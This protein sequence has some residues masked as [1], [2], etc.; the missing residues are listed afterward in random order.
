[1]Q[2][3]GLRF[4]TGKQKAK[5]KLLSNKTFVFTGELGSMSRHQAEAL[6]RK[7]GGH[8]SSSVSK[9]TDYVVAG[10]APGTK[11]EK[12]KKLGVRII[13]EKEFRKLVKL[14]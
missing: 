3:T 2:K 12:A 9:K 8:P 5:Q 11:Y 6:V 1:M 14:G 10:K 13:D 7:Y 4:H